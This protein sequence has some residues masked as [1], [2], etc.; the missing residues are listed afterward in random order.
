V[1][2][3]SL[4]L[5][6]RANGASDGV[7]LGRAN[8]PSDGVL[9]LPGRPNCVSGGWLAVPGRP[10]SRVCWGPRI[11]NVRGSFVGGTTV[12]CS[13][14]IGGSDS[15]GARLWTGK[16]ANGVAVGDFAVSSTTTRAPIFSRS[17]R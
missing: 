11:V 17:R 2:G 4:A 10:G 14:T 8:C 6:W 7:R 3:A 1:Y 12:A 13:A 5:L 15:A 9:A 16:P